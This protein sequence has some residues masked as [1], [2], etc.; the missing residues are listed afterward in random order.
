MSR[1]WLAP[2]CCV[3]VGI[4]TAGG[5]AVAQPVF[6]QGAE[7]QVNRYTTGSQYDPSIAVDADG[8]FVVVWSDPS[9][10]VDGG[11]GI[12]GVRFSSAGAVL[13]TEFHVNTYT[14]SIQ[15]RAQVAIE[16][17]GDF[18]VVWQ[19]FNQASAGDYTVFGQR[20]TSAGARVGGEFQVNSRTVF[21]SWQPK[22]ASDSDG[23]FVVVWEAFSADGSA[24]GVFARRFNSSGSAV[25]ID[26]MV[27]TFTDQ[28][29]T[30]PVIASQADGDFVIA[31]E[32]F[33]QIVSGGY[34]I[35]AKRFNSAGTAQA[36]EFQVNRYTSDS[37]DLPAIATDADGDF[38][39]AW[40]SLHQDS[41]YLGIFA[42]RFDSAG[43]GQANEFMVNTYTTGDQREPNIGADY[44]GDF[45]VTWED[46]GRDGS[47]EGTF[48]RRITFAGAFG[49]E[50]QA[51]S[52]TQFGQHQA[53]GHTSSQAVDFDA[54]GHFVVTWFTD[55]YQDGS[56]AGVFAQRF[57]LP[58]L[59]TLDIDGNGVI[60]PLTDGLLNL[61]HRFGFG[62]STLTNGAVSGTCTRCAAG[63]ITAYL[64]GLGLTLDI[65]N[66]GALEPLTDGLLVLRFMF[67]FTGTTLTNGAVANNCVTR[68]DPAS[69]LTYLQ[70]LD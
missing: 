58:P 7:F 48:A 26:F 14:E 68:C 51:N 69:I 67:G 4:L 25:G 56:G 37:Q 61:R 47:D 60:E 39:V 70:T 22:I 8:D 23:D 63:D 10:E 62:G 1:C 57:S 45:V 21:Y 46:V 55:A 40:N 2:L 18:V 59:A 16:S 6:R 38:V 11:K 41:G 36:G 43:V 12:W 20:F 35:F 64:N 33:N 31:W 3:A 9:R 24:G 34:D 27:N 53:E 65:D 15:H 50:F 44:S 54:D 28:N 66:N 32:S 5:P 13:G 19:S 49:P 17:N 29:Q 42:R 52:Y 30:G